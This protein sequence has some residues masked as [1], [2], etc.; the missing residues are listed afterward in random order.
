MSADTHTESKVVHRILCLSC[1]E[2]YLD[3]FKIDAQQQMTVALSAR[4]LSKSLFDQ[5]LVQQVVLRIFSKPWRT[6]DR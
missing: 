2:T 6:V 4:S 1:I 5:S 3:I